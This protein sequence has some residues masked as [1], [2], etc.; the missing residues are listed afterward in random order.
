MGKDLKGKYLGSG[1]SQRNDGKYSA[2]YTDVFGKRITFYDNKLPNVRKKMADDKYE[3]ENGL[4]GQTGKNITVEK[5]FETWLTVYKKDFIADSTFK[6]YQNRFNKNIKSAIG[7]MYL[8][9]VKKNHCQEILNKMYDDLL[10]YGTCNQAKITLRA[11]FQG[12]VEEG[13]ISKNPAQ[14]AICKQRTKAIHNDKYNSQFNFDDDNDEYVKG[15]ERR[16]LLLSEQ[17][18]FL[19]YT[20]N[21]P[22]YNAFVLCLQT[23][24]RAGEIGG[25]KWNDIDFENNTLSVKRTLLYNKEHG[26]YYFG[27]PKTKTSKRTIPMT[28]DVITILKKQKVQT[29]KLR[30]LSKEW[31][32]NINHDD[33]IF[34]TK[35]GLP[36]GT[37]GYATALLRI[38]TNI[39]KERKVISEMNKADFVEFGHI[40]MHCFRHTYATRC[41]ENGMKPKTLQKLLGHS[42]ISTTMDLYVHVT[43]E[44]MIKEVNLAVPSIRKLI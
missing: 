1:V 28:E 11:L 40:Y 19:T 8:K 44:E 42:Q 38:V 33:L 16:V 23:G 43:D 4:R 3:K 36:I 41:I 18:E 13:Y 37:S 30:A 31:T 29:F 14:Q 25:L 5:W 6:N 15:K 27:K 39:N 24:L 34:V 17:D 32:T 22:Y 10:S 2:R 21:S 9:N 35:N 12:A 20:V 26:G 7:K